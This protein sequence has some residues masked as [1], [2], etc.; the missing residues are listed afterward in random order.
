MTTKDDE[1]VLHAPTTRMLSAQGAS[2]KVDFAGAFPPDTND[3]ILYN[4]LQARKKLLLR[5]LQV[6]L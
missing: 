1:E 5:S 4:R 2:P 3:I 6:T